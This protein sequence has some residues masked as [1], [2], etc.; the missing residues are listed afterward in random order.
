MEGSLLALVLE[1]F[2]VLWWPEAWLAILSFFSI[3]TYRRQRHEP[4]I[5]W[6]L[7]G[8]LPAVLMNTHGFYDW[9]TGRL[10]AAG[11]TIRFKGPIFY[12]TNVVMTCDPRNMEH[13]LRT[14][15]E[16]FPKG[17]DFQDIFHDLFGDG[18]A[19]ADAESWNFQRKLAHN[20][21]HSKDFRQFS[22]KNTRDI[23]KTQLVPL[24]RQWARQNSVLDIQ[25]VFSRFT[26]DTACVA[27]FG[28]NPR[29]LSPSF[30]RLPASEA[31]AIIMDAIF[32]RHIVPSFVWHLFR[33][34]QVG[35]EMG[36][37]HSK[38]VMKEL[39]TQKVAEKKK[40]PGSDDLLSK[41]VAVSSDDNFLKDSTANFLL[42]ARD[43]S[44][45]ALTW[46]FWLLSRHP[47]A[48]AKILKELHSIITKKKEAAADATPSSSSPDFDFG[49][50]VLQ[51][52]VYLH[53]ALC[54]TL[55]LYPSV[56]INNRSVL[57]EDKLPDGTVLK[58]GTKVF[59]VPY[60]AGRMKWAW[61]EDCLEFKPE[62]WIDG[63]GRLKHE[64]DGS[65]FAAFNG[66]PR[67]CLG[68]DIAFLQ[69]K[70]AAAEVLLNFEVTVV[71]GNQVSPRTSVLMSMKQGLPV[72]VKERLSANND[73][74]A[75]KLLR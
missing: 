73:D 31:I 5:S 75:T 55:R 3:I 62:R 58:P 23:V 2:S 15:F 27:A 9:I 28:D 41:Y 53:A 57:A 17:E 6:P 35:K 61:G 50:E 44:A 24:L 67:T 56:P 59:F 74:K 21:I 8:M 25:D 39:L 52:M 4:I 47:H 19:N 43:T 54:E 49:T 48:E 46:F 37:N 40:S 70:Y 14:N 42:A 11:G 66:G 51:K 32:Y 65:R 29:C 1:T 60:A 64:T 12:R 63:E 34:L 72:M 33:R 7:V 13:I 71:E 45:A 10:A 20:K 22:L 36:V 69:M 26:Y 30:P 16:N 38:E 18:L 68:K